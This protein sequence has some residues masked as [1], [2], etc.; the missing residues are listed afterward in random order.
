MALLKVERSLGVLMSLSASLNGFCRKCWPFF[1]DKWLPRKVLKYFLLLSNFS[2]PPTSIA[3][4]GVRVL[5]WHK[6]HYYGQLPPYTPYCY[7]PQTL[8]ETRLSIFFLCCPILTMTRKTNY[9]FTTLLLISTYT[10]ISQQ[11]GVF[12][13]A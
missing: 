7:L 10:F 13:K 8:L 4:V 1:G 9:G 2:I 6:L 3:L 5:F 12:R 11:D